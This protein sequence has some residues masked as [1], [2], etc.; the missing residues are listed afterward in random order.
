MIRNFDSG[1]RSTRLGTA[2]GECDGNSRDKVS[3]TDALLDSFEDI[4]VEDASI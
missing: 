2:F 1:G 3:H 4:L